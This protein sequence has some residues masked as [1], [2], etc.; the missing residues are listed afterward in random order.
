MK[1]IREFE[2]GK[3]YK[4]VGHQLS[5]DPFTESWTSANGRCLKN[6]EPYDIEMNAWVDRK[7]R[8][9]T[10][11]YRGTYAAFENIWSPNMKIFWDVPCDYEAY[12]LR[13]FFMEVE[14]DDNGVE[15]K[16]ASGTYDEAAF[17]VL[18]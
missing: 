17:V 10:Y 1:A 12:L 3:Y 16:S 18:P 6:L 13:S 11:S 4:F 9:C 15:K 5:W 8:K 2:V 14:V 7:P